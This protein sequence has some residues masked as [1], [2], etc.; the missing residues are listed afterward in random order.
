[1]ISNLL[2]SVTD[3]SY[4]MIQPMRTST[5][6]AMLI[7][8]KELPLTIPKPDLS[9]STALL[10]YQRFSDLRSS[11][12]HIVADSSSPVV[13]LSLDPML[14]GTDA[15]EPISPACAECVTDCIKPTCP[16][17]EITPQCTDQCV[18]IACS[19]PNHDQMNCNGAVDN[20]HCD[21]ACDSA[22]DCAGCPGFE[23]FVRFFC[24]ACGGGGI[25]IFIHRE[26]S[27]I[28]AQIIIRISPS[29]KPIL[30]TLSTGLLLLISPSKPYS[31]DVESKIRI[32]PQAAMFHPLQ[33][34]PISCITRYL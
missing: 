15:A 11:D 16:A 30:R 7:P 20:T 2:L 5:V 1:M 25:L 4:V 31:A 27:F 19:D 6:K 3:V 8:R 21:I 33:N 23:D 12:T 24:R 17:A 9:S 13:N 34:L 18:V 29:P 14:V 22:V 10:R 32:Q 26:F 28:V